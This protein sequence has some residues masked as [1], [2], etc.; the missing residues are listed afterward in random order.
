MEYFGAAYFGTVSINIAKNFGNV[1]GVNWVTQSSIGSSF[2]PK[3]F[4]FVLDNA[5]T[6]KPEL[7]IYI[8]SK[9]WISL[10]LKAMIKDESY[11]TI[12]EIT[13]VNTGQDTDPSTNTTTYPAGKK[14][15]PTI[16]MG[17]SYPQN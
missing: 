5:S 12:S 13:A 3:F 11:G 4:F 1:R 10:Y 17:T 8:E 2:E 14:Q 7:W 6:N 15:I 16:V 9:A